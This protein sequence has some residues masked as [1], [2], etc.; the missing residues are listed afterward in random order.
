MVAD[1]IC[2]YWQMVMKNNKIQGV[3]VMTMCHC[4]TR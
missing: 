4:T 1:F 2:F 3:R